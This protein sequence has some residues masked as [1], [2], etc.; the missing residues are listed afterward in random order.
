[1]VMGVTDRWG[2]GDLRGFGLFLG[3]LAVLALAVLLGRHVIGAVAV[4]RLVLKVCAMRACAADLAARG[5][6]TRD[7]AILGRLVLWSRSA[8]RFRVV[9]PV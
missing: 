9:G 1:M 4:V 7:G 8:A 6:V 3:F 2:V 5:R